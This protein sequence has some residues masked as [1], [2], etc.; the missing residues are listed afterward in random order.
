MR[1]FT[2]QGPRDTVLSPLDSILYHKSLLH[3]GLMSIEPQTGHV[4]AWVGGMDYR[5]FK[6]DNVSQSKRQVGSIFKPF[7]YATALR[8][9]MER[10]T[11]LPNQ[12][13][14][15]E[16]PGDQPDWCPDNSDFEYGE[17]W[18]IR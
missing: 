9:G 12:R 10:C 6:Y 15:V 8:Y 16:M 3:A 4:K 18:P 7:V 2:H 17:L 11:E 13:I 1:V 5:Y 14:C